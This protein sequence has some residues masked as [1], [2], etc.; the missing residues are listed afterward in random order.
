MQNFLERDLEDLIYFSD[1]DKLREKGLDLR[2]KLYRQFNV[3]R[4]GIIDLLTVQRIPLNYPYR[5]SYLNITIYELKRKTINQDSLMQS[6]QYAR[7]IQSYLQKR[8][9]GIEFTINITIIGSSVDLNSNVPYVPNLIQD[10]SLMG[11][12]LGFISNIDYVQ[13]EYNIDGIMFE[14]CNDFSLIHEGF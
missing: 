5:G 1:K 4:Y 3:G 14:Y 6:I 13:Y 2:G 9:E 12:N 10:N 8:R 11:V 7:G